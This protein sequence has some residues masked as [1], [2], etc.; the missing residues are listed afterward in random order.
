LLE[1][2]PSSHH[3]LHWHGDTFDLPEAAVLLA[4]SEACQHQAFSLKDGR[5]LGL[6]FHFEVDEEMVQQFADFDAAVLKEGGNWVQ[7]QLQI[8]KEAGEY[9]PGCQS[10]MKTLVGRWLALT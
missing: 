2:F 5:V 1:G 9:I 6:Q 10:L 3:V 8:L 7:S 4:S